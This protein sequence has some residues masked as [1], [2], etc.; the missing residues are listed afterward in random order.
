MARIV[1]PCCDEEKELGK[2]IQVLSGMDDRIKRLFL[3]KGWAGEC[4]NM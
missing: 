2:F 3:K 1:L 4:N